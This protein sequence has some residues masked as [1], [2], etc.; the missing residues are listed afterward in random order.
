[1]KKKLSFN[2]KINNCVHFCLHFRVHFEVQIYFMLSPRLLKME[3]IVRRCPFLS[4]VSQA[5]L[6]KAGK[7]LLFYAQNCPKMMEVGTKPASRA[8]STSAT[9]CQQTEESTS[10]SQSKSTLIKLTN[11]ICHE[12][13][14]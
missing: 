2:L 9:H 3:T 4:R 5:F 12:Q 6:Q 13:K 7:S 14:S 11:L 1:M 8:I 10:A